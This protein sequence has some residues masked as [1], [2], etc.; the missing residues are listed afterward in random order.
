MSAWI[1]LFFAANLALGIAI[2]NLRGRP[3]EG[4]LLALVLGPIGW[5]IVL[6]LSDKRL[7]PS[8]GTD[9]GGVR[10]RADLARGS[11]GTAHK[12]MDRWTREVKTAARRLRISKA[13][14]AFMLL[15]Y[16]VSL[17]TGFVLF[18]RIA[19][20]GSSGTGFDASLGPL[21]N[22][23]PANPYTLAQWGVAGAAVAW[24]S[25]ILLKKRFA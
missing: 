17:L 2:G 5:L 22:V 24:V 11:G 13:L 15:G 20:P 21:G 18:A 3:A 10:G 6:R 7:A 12:P 8:R 9:L 16:A 14:I 23:L 1:I 4:L 19:A 25:Q